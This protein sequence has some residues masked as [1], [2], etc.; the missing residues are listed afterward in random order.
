M[1]EIVEELAQHLEDRYAELVGS[2][3]PDQEAQRLLLDELAARNVLQDELRR[4][5]GPTEPAPA[6]LGSPGAGGPWR[7]L[8]S[9]VRYGTRSLRK[10]P[11]LTAVALL[12]LSLGIGAN[13]AIFS[14]VNAVL[15]QPLPFADPDRLVTFWGSAP[16]MGLPVV[17]YPDAFYVYFRTRSRVLQPIAAYSSFGATLTGAGDPERL[18]GAAVTADFFPLLGRTPQQGRNFLPE[19]EARDRN[20]VTLLAT[21]SGNAASAEIRRSSGSH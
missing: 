10:S 9:D 15:L 13:A 18:N 2:G 12:T 4:L 7:G 5:A 19:E 20:Q 17:N 14:V 11:G 16:E 6:V 1:E 21:G 3:T 8:W